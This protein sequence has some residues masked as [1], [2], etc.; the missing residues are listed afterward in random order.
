[1][2]T[3]LE[4]IMLT[5]NLIITFMNTNNIMWLIGEL[6]IHVSTVSLKINANMEQLHGL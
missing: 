4:Y 3:V 5:R 2:C 6:I 1:M